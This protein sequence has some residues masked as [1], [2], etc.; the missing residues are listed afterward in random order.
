MKKTVQFLMLLFFIFI[1]SSILPAQVQTGSI[2]GVITDQEGNPLPAVTVTASSPSLMGVQTYV[3]PESGAFRF[4]A[5]PPG[6]YKLVFKGSGFKPITREN[7]IVRVGM[8]VTINL[9]LEQKVLEQEIT[10]TAPSPTVDVK[11]TKIASVI[12]KDILKNIPLARDLY[13]IINTAPGAVSEAATRSRAA[14]H[15]ST[16]RGNTYAFDGVTMNDPAVMSPLTNINFDVIE[17]IEIETAGH[18]ASIGVTDGAYINVVTKSGGNRFS[19]AASLYYTS[20]GMN[21][22]LWPTEQVNALG[23][24]QPAVDKSWTDLSLSFGG[25]IL[26]DKI[27]F[28][29][30]GRYIRR[31][32]KTNF[33]PFTDI[34]GRSHDAYDWTHEE[35]MGFVKLTAQLTPKLK[36]MLMTNYVGIYQPMYDEPGPRTPFIST[37]V[38]DHEK[39]YAGDVV[40]NYILDQNTFAEL[41]V[42]YVRRFFSVPMQKESQ[43]LPWIDDAGDLY[44][45]LTGARYNAQYIRK[46]AQ[47]LA[48]FTRFQDN[49]LGASHEFKGA[50]EFEDAYFDYD[51]WRKDNMQWYMDSRN[52]NNYYF[53]DSGYLGFWIC[54]PES[55]SSKIINR[56]QR[57][58]AYL[59]DNATFGKRLSV[60]LG[61]RFDRSWGWNPAVSKKAA[62][63]PVA[64]LLGE[65][66][67]SP[68]LAATYP[69]RFPN[70]LNP[71]GAA[72]APEWKD[73]M[74]WNAWAPRIGFSYDLFGNGMTA[75][76]ASFS[77]YNE[78]LMIQYF[79]SLHPFYPRAFNFYW[80]DTNANGRPDVADSY[81]SV[82]ADF[83]GLDPEFAK[84]QIKPGTKPPTTD[85]FIVGIWQDLL[86]NVSL[87][88]NFIYKNKSNILEDV[89]YAPDTGEYWYYPDQAATKK[90]WIPF[91]TTVPGTDKYPDQTVTFYVRSNASPLPFTQLNNV[92][93]LKRKY[94][95]LE[96]V[97]NKRMADGWQFMG[98]LV[99]SK[100]YG[101]L[102]AFYNDS[103]GWTDAGNSPNSFV[104]AY[105]LINSDRP[106]QIKLM[107]TVQLPL[108][109]YFSTFFQYMSGQPWER[110]VNIQPPAAWCAAN[111]ANRTYYAVKLEQAGDRRERSSNSLDFRVEKE[112]RIGSTATIGAYMDMINVL[113]SSA[114]SVGLNDVYRWDPVAEGAGQ[115]GT[116]VLNSNYRIISAVS[117]L[118]TFKFGVRFGF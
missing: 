39:T 65:T 68:Y 107:S 48:S 15:G 66:L 19:G 105:G 9:A 91:T 6:T 23:V 61:I 18:P 43:D 58:G 26:K 69:D 84:Q 59:Q 82:P 54:G 56:A 67:V 75:L 97:L 11:S 52:P 46:R 78:Y 21:K 38:W 4:P 70:G 87:G 80:L 12:D 27:W 57:I 35:T 113:G 108:G 73:I 25:P 79:S 110:S 49:W 106:L 34:L 37:M 111:N 36:F 71:Y 72:S 88:V 94:W 64:V 102:G 3:T 86:K 101:N 1:L 51:W 98:S 92:P 96:F 100:T 117:G 62:G 81:S 29:A 109:I 55:G 53:K 112:F 30:N 16:V 90:Y 76:K 7:V 114:L 47:V 5:L 22:M 83:R 2:K 8:T 118:R 63:N 40:M 99:Y 93:E 50:V 17:E 115:P 95:A 45:P 77:R 13:D 74:V 28:F 44:G 116:K 85:E 89:L 104:N 20:E 10:V 32:Q 41:R 103:W 24:V 33:I 42:G 31:E 14:V 60:N